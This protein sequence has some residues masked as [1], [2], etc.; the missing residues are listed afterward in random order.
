[1]NANTA[2]V[3]NAIH[4]ARSG[5]EEAARVA[6][7]FFPHGSN[8]ADVHTTNPRRKTSKSNIARPEVTVTAQHNA[9][10]KS[11]NKFIVSCSKTKIS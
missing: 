6:N 9:G 5:A 7:S 2:A 4:S 10:C 8:P 1:M 11:S 3:L